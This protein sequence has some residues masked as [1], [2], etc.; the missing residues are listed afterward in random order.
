MLRRFQP[1]RRENG[2]GARSA[3]GRRKKKDVR[4]SPA[5]APQDRCI[6]GQNERR[7]ER[8]RDEAWRHVYGAAREP[9]EI[10]SSVINGAHRPVYNFVKM[11]DTRE[12]FT[13]VQLGRPAG[14]LYPY[15][16]R[17]FFGQCWDTPGS[18]RR[19]LAARGARVVS[20]RH[21]GT[22]MSFSRCLIV[23]NAPSGT[24]YELLFSVYF[25]LMQLLE[26]L[27]ILDKWCSLRFTFLLI[28]IVKRKDG[29]IFSM[30]CQSILLANRYPHDTLNAGR[31]IGASMY[32]PPVF[33]N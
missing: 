18:A 21:G 25:R 33:F 4:T 29:L 13:L 9:R 26:N 30:I 3:R 31:S 6:T 27:R 10:G 16:A 14:F 2:A 12:L 17:F 28:T 23:I 32:L 8:E 1:R 19:K 24:Y 5:A 11:T 20:H 15:V 22:A 7:R